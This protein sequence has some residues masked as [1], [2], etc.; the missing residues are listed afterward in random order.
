[1]GFGDVRGRLR[2]G[3]ADQEQSGEV[4]LGQQSSSSSF[5]TTHHRPPQ[6]CHFGGRRAAY[7]G[8]AEVFQEARSF[9]GEDPEGRF[10]YG[11]GIEST[12]IIWFNNTSQAAVR[13]R[14]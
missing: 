6:S 11:L 7:Q 8:N 14:C 13:E 10:L 2:L 12:M 1:M 4:P 9:P 5:S 3:G